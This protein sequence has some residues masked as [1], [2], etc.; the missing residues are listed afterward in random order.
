MNKKFWSMTKQTN[1]SAD[2][3]LY[4]PISESSWWGDEITPKQFADDLAALGDVGEINVR[5][6]SGGGDVFAGQAIHSMLKRH[7]ANVTVYI[8]GLAASIASI[9]AMAGDTVIMP[10]GAMMMVHNPWTCAWGDS[11]ELRK[12]ADTLDKVRESLISVYE[13]KTGMSR[14]DITA[15][16]DE[17]T[18]LT[19]EEAV[20]KGFADQVEEMAISASLHDQTLTV[21]GQSFDLMKYAKVPLKVAMMAME[22]KPTPTAEPVAK[23]EPK[24]PE[25]EPVKN[26]IKKQ[27]G[28]DMNEL[29]K[30]ERA[31]VFEIN[32]MAEHY[33]VDKKVRDAWIESGAT[34][35]TVRKEIMDQQMAEPIKVK[36]EP[37]VVVGADERDKFK[38]A[39][40]DAL[41]MRCGLKVDKPADGAKELRGATLFDM[42]KES[43]SRAGNLPRTY[44]RLEIVKAAM[45]QGTSD[46][47][48][49]LS[50]VVSKSMMT[51]Y[52]MAPVTYQLWT[53][54]GNLSDYKVASRLQISEFG[55][56]GE[57]KEGAEYKAAQLSD[58]AETIQLKKYG[59]I[60]SITREA[61]VNDDLQA[62]SDIPAKFGAAARFTVENAV[63]GILT[64]NPTMADSVALFE[65]SS[66][67]NYTSSG[68]AL[69]VASLG[70]GKAAMRK[71]K[72]L[73]GKQTLNISPVYLIV[74]A[75]KE[76]I[77]M[78]LINST[79]DPAKTNNTPN[80]F[81]NQLTVVTCPILDAASTTAWYLAAAPGFIDT[82][83]VAFLNGQDTPYLEQRLGFEV[84]GI[85][86]KV[87]HEFGYKALDFRGMY[88]NV[89]A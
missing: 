76:M 22:K 80:P 63:Y 58:T 62:L 66:H 57:V 43:L 47:P 11:E 75:E 42:A 79:V 61:V 55:A 88:K 8:D 17:E 3:L 87:R 39:A 73:A 25:N 15:L 46:F 1:N 67:K 84:D 36:A 12:S 83:E 35:D 20:E 65:A 14:D 56:L 68:T 69:S 37:D 77:A 48:N 82:I 13:D 70:V 28:T 54:R 21:N 32:A 50:N 41:A 38:A 23:V 30:A 19:A 78:Q 44:D 89:G 40:T 49:V 81:A 31:R 64:N 2:L 27:E 24:E 60:F 85:E 7:A 6:N 9:I 33:G 51:A 45:G 86:Y 34:V 10:K 71:Q 4:G 59:N 52:D 53:K 18:W 29:I 16:M 26:E 72:G 74:P 5:I